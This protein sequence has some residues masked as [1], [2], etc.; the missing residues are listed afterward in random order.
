[1]MRILQN[2]VFRSIT[3]W[4]LFLE[5][6]L[7]L[8]RYRMM[9]LKQMSLLCAQDSKIYQRFTWPSISGEEFWWPSVSST[10]SSRETRRT[11]NT[12]TAQKKKSY[13]EETFFASSVNYL[14]KTWVLDIPNFLLLVSFIQDIKASTCQDFLSILCLTWLSWV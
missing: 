12:T 14:H 11:P 10:S 13:N 8:I 9:S 7:D 2:T 5:A 1:M 4:C 6:K 3:Q